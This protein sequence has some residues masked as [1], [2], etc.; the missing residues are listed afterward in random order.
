MFADGRTVPQ[1]EVVKTDVCVVGAG[2]A[3]ITIGRELARA[4]VDVLIVERGPDLHEGPMNSPDTAVNAGLP[5]GVNKSRTFGVGGAIHKWHVETPLGDGFGRLRELDHSDFAIRP[6]I[7]FSGWPIDKTHLRAYY[8]RARALFDDSG[9]S[10]A[11]DDDWDDLL[12]DSRFKPGPSVS[13]RVFT[14]ANPGVFAGEHRR[15]LENSPA[16]LVLSN[17]VVTGIL[18][19]RSL[20]SVSSLS[21]K[22]SQSHSFTIEARYYVLAAGGIE[23]PRLLLASRSRHTNGMGNAHDLVGRFFMEHPHYPSG[24]LVPFDPTAFDDIGSYKVF[25]HD[26]IPVQ[27]KYALSESIIETEALNRSVFQLIPSLIDEQVRSI[28][29]SNAGVEAIEAANRIHRAL[30][31][32]RRSQRIEGDTASVLRGSPHLV[33]YAFHRAISRIGSRL[34]VAKYGSMHGFW[35][36]GMAEQVP[37]PESRVALTEPLDLFGM[38]RA[39]LEWRLTSQD[40]HSIERTQTLLGIA[41][42]DRGDLSV[43]SFVQGKKVPPRLGGG[44]HHMGTTRMADSE[45]YGVVNANCRVHG[46]S[47][48]YIAGSSVFPTGGYANPT[49]TLLAL[50]IRLA[51]HIRQILEPSHVSVQDRSR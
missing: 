35:I 23:N 22:T 11:I 18:S 10:S 49:L 6:W 42:A 39:S 1:G 32:P 5:Y 34:G 2:P 38:P 30:H 7:R 47:N 19:D 50:A 51:D 28:R 3:G 31:N 44:N 45:R 24:Y 13:T 14:F 15:A 33:R 25:L 29:F 21:I 27:R 46:V 12:Q 20:D 26:G 16:A 40:M 48:L 17:A 37:D 43:E 41:L 4:G 8:D 36:H 9:Q